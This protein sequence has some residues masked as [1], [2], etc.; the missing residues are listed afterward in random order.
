MSP[1]LDFEKEWLNEPYGS[2]IGLEGSRLFA[3][4]LRDLRSKTQGTKPNAS[5]A[6]SKL[7][8]FISSIPL[9]WSKISNSQIF[10]YFSIFKTR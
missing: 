3:A 9:V 4:L 2:P 8:V 1:K 6:K 7:L 10:Y 5:N